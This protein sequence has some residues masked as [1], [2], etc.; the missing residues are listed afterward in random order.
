M[1]QNMLMFSILPGALI[2]QATLIDYFISHNLF[3]LKK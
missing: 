2:D 1:K 3:V